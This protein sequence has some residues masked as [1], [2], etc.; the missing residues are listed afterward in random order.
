MSSPQPELRIA[1]LVNHYPAVSHTFIR[2]EIL[3]LERLGAKVERIALR[4]WDTDLADAQDFAERSRTRY[5]LQGGAGRLAGAVVRELLRSPRRFV[6]GLATAVRMGRRAVR[7]LPYHLVYL[8]EACVV[9]GW[10]RDRQVQH[11]HAHFGTNPAELALLVK[12]LGGPSYSFTV[13][14]PTEF[15]EPAYCKLREKTADAAFVV[16]ITS[17]AR[18]QLFRWIRHAD[19]SK[20]NVV[21]C[22]FEPSFRHVSAGAPPRAPRLACIGRLSHEKGQLMVVEAAA[23]ILRKGM[24]LELV[25]GGDG[26]LRAEIE[27]LIRHH[28]IGAHVRVT[29]WLS[30]EQVRDELLA[31]RALLLP[32]FAEGLPVVVME[33]MALQRPVLTTYI[34]GIPEL[35]VPGQNGWLFPAGDIDQ[36]VECIEACLA[37]SPEEL[38]RMGAAARLRVLSRHDADTEAARLLGHFQAQLARG[39]AGAVRVP[40]RVEQ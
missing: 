35:V 11:V 3:A 16:A 32:S 6:T 8:A 13:H 19:W 5:V 31:S 26:E 28:G 21:R 36:L 18:S 29:G 15:D 40:D 7:P 9:L 38:A 4:G 30:G 1:Y 17:F 10:L 14:G 37:A 12:A 34:A 2:R 22:A 33:A 39:E 23:R 20:V 27:A 25:L 24:A